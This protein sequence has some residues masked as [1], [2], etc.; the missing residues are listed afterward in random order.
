[1]K[2]Q[3]HKLE[4]NSSIFHYRII[5]PE[6]ESLEWIMGQGPEDPI[7]SSA[8]IKR[9]DLALLPGTNVRMAVVSAPISLLSISHEKAF[10][11]GG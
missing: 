7:V 3:P 1:M 4:D 5:S 2:Y 11:T 8:A 6:M 10:S 9:V